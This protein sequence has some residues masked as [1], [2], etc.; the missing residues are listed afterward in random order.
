MRPKI[1]TLVG[2]IEAMIIDV[3]VILDSS[4]MSDERK[5]CARKKLTSSGGKMV[6][7]MWK[8]CRKD[9]ALSFDFYT[10]SRIGC[11]SFEDIALVG[12]ATRREHDMTSPAEAVSTK[13]Y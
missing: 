8:N 11:C 3:I 4:L 7:F 1:M 2:S 12:F 5:P 9:V 6:S 10:N 13:G